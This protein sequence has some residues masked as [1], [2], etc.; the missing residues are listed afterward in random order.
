M[1]NNP[2]PDKS[3]SS[4]EKSA[5]LDAGLRAA[6]GPESQTQ[7]HGSES[8]LVTLKETLGVRSQVLLRDASDGQGPV[9][10]PHSAEMPELPATTGRYQI[11]GEIARGGVGV[12][13]KGRDVDLG[14]DVAMKV[15]RTNHATNPAMV[16]RFMEE[17]QITGQLQHPGILPVY[18]LGLQHNQ[19]PYFTMKLVKGRTLSALLADRVDATED[20]R[21]FLNI[22]EHI[23]Q[24]MAYAH[25]RG[26]VHR[27]LK[28]SN[29]MVGAFGE[30]QVVDWGLA[31]VLLQGGVA[32]ENKATEADVAHS[33]IETIRSGESGSQSLAGSV[34]GT[35]AYM[36]PEQ[37]R[38]E[39]D[40][41]NERSD[42]FALGAI[43]CEILTGF[44]PYIGGKNEVLQQA[45]ECRMDDARSRLENCGADGELIEITIRCLAPALT[46]R[47][48]SAEVVARD[49]N[50][51]LAGLE[52]K[53]MA[54]ELSAA[55]SRARAQEERRAR[56]LTVA[57][58][59]AVLFAVLLVGGG[60]FWNEQAQ[61]A[62]VDTAGRM[63]NEALAKAQISLGEAKASRVGDR[64]KWEAVLSSA[65]H[66]EKLIEQADVPD[67][68]RR[69]AQ[70]FIGH[71][72]R[73][74]ADRRI[75][76]R[77]E[78]VIVVGATHQDAESWMWMDDQLIQAFLDYGIDVLNMPHE[79]IVARIRESE[80]SV[81]LTNGLE[82]WINTGGDLM[83]RFGVHRYT[84]EMFHKRIEML[85]EADPDP[86]RTKLRKL[87]YSLYFGKPP[88]LQALRE[89]AVS[90][91]LD[92]VLPITLAWLGATF[93]LAG[94]MK[95]CH[96]IFQ[97]A[98]LVYP[99]DFTLNFDYALLLSNFNS[100]DK[101]IPYL[102][103]CLAIRPETGGIWRGLGIE[104]RK[105]G[106]LENAVASFE[107][108]IECQPDHMPTFIDLGLTLVEMKKIDEA[109]ETYRNAIDQRPD[110][111]LAH[112]Y[113]GRALQEKG[114]LHEA[115]SE[116][117]RCDEL[118]SRNPTWK[119]P[120][121]DWIKECRR[122]I[123]E[124]EP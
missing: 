41:L 69:R 59:T 108:S 58:A 47:P 60:F 78:E 113:L 57:L 36:P 100:P 43:L 121:K 81:E 46:A 114:L 112:G 48:R 7:P 67:D 66:I 51:Y 15:L 80:I 110:F 71:L 9:V 17:A 4:E 55:E 1:N 26:V 98:M 32:D 38:G 44:P 107:K 92:E 106:D 45:A 65:E 91:P 120:S 111:A 83:G 75:L 18:E 85:Y 27:D 42:V 119:Y 117:K 89:L 96:D 74:D 116:L 53:A 23:C 49:I 11:A 5:F 82:L 21:R 104:Q 109:I 62:R 70:D 13:L 90:K 22:F 12:V 61:Q 10:N 19:R 103:R 40:K 99:D 102:M 76:E 34:M 77:I 72:E 115:L 68:A 37:A 29:I 105:A 24:T 52:E 39:V 88:D 3:S 30:V 87:M 86:Y 97:R 31:K 54:L 122:L 25:A 28:P 73:A 56:R 118:G 20:R 101:A 50:K 14:R 6:F 64:A 63:M 2:D 16:Q 8:V 84:R 95:A 33:A 94:D 35:P 123:Q 93:A 124:Q 79:E